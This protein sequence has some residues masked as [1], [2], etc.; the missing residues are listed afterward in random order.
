MAADVGVDGADAAELV[1]L[2][3]LLSDWLDSADAELL[4]ASLARFVGSDAYDLAE[5][6][7]DPARFVLL[8]GVDSEGLFGGP[9]ERQLG[10]ARLQQLTDQLGGFGVVEAFAGPVVEFGD[11]GVEV[12]LAVHQRSVPFGKYWRS[13]PLVLPAQ[14]PGDLLW[15]ILPLQVRLHHR[16]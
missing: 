13:R 5:L 6:R 7:A 1:E 4:E 8:G 2:L 14:S 15:R 3:T 10:L 9:T 11:H 16:R 12:G